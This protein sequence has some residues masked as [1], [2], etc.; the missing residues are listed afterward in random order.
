MDDRLL[1]A[2][3]AFERRRD[4]ILTRLR[5]HLHH[6]IVG[7]APILHQ[8]ADE[9]EFGRARGRETDLDLLDADFHQQVEEA[10]LLLRIH[11]VNQRLIAIAQIG[12]EPARGAGDDI[13]RPLAV[14]QVDL[15]EGAIFLGWISQ[16]HGSATSFANGRA[17]IRWRA[18]RLTMISEKE[19]LRRIVAAHNRKAAQ[20]P[21][22]RA[23][24]S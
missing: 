21:R 19:A 8:R 13:A 9:V 6:H 15:G 11:R 10:A 3:Q 5:Q 17:A 1:R 22:L 4:Q 24:K 12:R 18:A 16:H 14:G 2:A 20:K 23:C 7:N